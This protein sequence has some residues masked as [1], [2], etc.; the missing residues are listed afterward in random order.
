M[1]FIALIIALLLEQRL[2]LDYARYVARPGNAALAFLEARLNAGNHRQGMYAALIALGLPFFCLL[3]LYIAFL[4]RPLLAFALNVACLYFTMG[5]RQFSHFYTDI[6]LALRIADSERARDLLGKFLTS[7]MQ[8]VPPM[9]G[10]GDIAHLAIETALLASFRHVFAVIFWFAVLPGP[11]GAVAYRTLHLMA[12]DWR[13]KGEFGRFA[14]Q[15][16]EAAE[17]LPARATAIA[18]AVVGNFE[19]AIYCWRRGCFHGHDKNMGVVLASGAGALGIRL[20]MQNA[21]EN[22]LAADADAMQSAIGLVWR[23]VLLLL[24]LLLL[25]W[26][27][28][29]AGSLSYQ[30]AVS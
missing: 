20:G 17:W 18:F 11:L 30:G 29:L 25:L 3:A 23:A 1:S 27:A 10:D 24:L 8:A 5:F 19:D 21:P 4:D 13:G 2:P 22:A 9:K 12:H 7:Q 6:Q 28:G 16:F 14:N 15:L 26:L